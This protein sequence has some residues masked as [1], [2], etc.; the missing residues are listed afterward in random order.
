MFQVELE[1]WWYL[2]M[3]QITRALLNKWYCA[4]TD[5][6]ILDA[7]CGTGAAMSTYLSNYGRVTGFDLSPVA[8]HYC[9]KRLAPLSASNVP[10]IVNDVPP[11]V[12]KVPSIVRA[13]ITQIPFPSHSFDL[14]ASFDV[15]YESSVS[16]DLTALQE[17]ARVLITGG[18]LLIRLPAYPWLRGQHDTVVHT[19]RRYTSG[20]LKRLLEHSGLVIEHITYA[21]TVLFPIA[22]LKRLSER[23]FQQTKPISDLALQTGPF[24]RLFQWILMLEAG[25]AAGP[26]L[27]YGLSVIAVGRKP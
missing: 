11:I 3:Q 21:N 15:L 9:R 10:S 18:R 23:F 19:A 12:N 16:D 22:A 1:H 4:R 20:Q 2:G 14:A 8:L 26:G 5:L 6:K 25:P 27:P 24:N 7:G 17:L 13:C